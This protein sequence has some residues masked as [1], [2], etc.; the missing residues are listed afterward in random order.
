MSCIRLYDQMCLCHFFVIIFMLV[1]FGLS[2]WILMLVGSIIRPIQTDSI[3]ICIDYKRIHV[4]SM[5]LVFQTSSLSSTHR[6]HETIYK[7]LLVEMLQRG[8]CKMISCLKRDFQVVKVMNDALKK[9]TQEN[10]T[11]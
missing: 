1:F 11:F 3:C 7:A 5:L 2:Y 9:K 8:L 4:P 10:K 6:V